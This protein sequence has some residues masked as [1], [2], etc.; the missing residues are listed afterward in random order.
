VLQAIDAV[1]ALG[2]DPADAAPDHWRHIH[3][4]LSAGERPRPYSQNRHQAWLNRRKL[5]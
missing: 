5:K 4:R 3:N 1:A 2:I